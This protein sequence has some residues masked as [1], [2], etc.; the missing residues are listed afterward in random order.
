MPSL[1]Q[2]NRVLLEK[3]VATGY[4]IPA[5]ELATVESTA[6]FEAAYPQAAN[7][8][9]VL[10]RVV[11]P[12]PD[13]AAERKAPNGLLLLFAQLE[14]GKKTIGKAQARSLIEIMDRENV[15]TAFFIVN[16]PLFAQA[17]D[18]IRERSGRLRVVVFSYDQLSFNVSQ[19]RRVPQH[20]LLSPPEAAEWLRLT[21]L[22]RSQLP[23]IFE[24]DPQARYLDATH[25]EL[26]KVVSASPTVG[27]FVKHLVVVRRIG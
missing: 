19:H 11:M 8:P 16:A 21:K 5:E 20:L 10:T 1:R 14:E 3:L 18:Y 25:N 6:A 22:K 13:T 15:T 26:I 24:D 4:D 2:I 7:Q 17:R 9:E 27:V 23:R 12:L